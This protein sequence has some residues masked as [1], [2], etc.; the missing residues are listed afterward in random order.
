VGGDLEWEVAWNGGDLE[1]E[2]VWTGGLEVVWCG[3]EWK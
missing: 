2:V 3:L 1:W